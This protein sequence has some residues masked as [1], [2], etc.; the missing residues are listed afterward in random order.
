MSP[1]RRR[2]SLPALPSHPHRQVVDRALDGAYR[3]IRFTTSEIHLTLA[4]FF[5]E[6][7][8]LLHS[9]VDLLLGEQH[10][11]KICPHT[12]TLMLHKVGNNVVEET[13]HL[14]I[15]A[16]RLTLDFVEEMMGQM[17]VRLETFLQRGSGYQLKNVE[18]LEWE[19]VQFEL[20]PFLT[21]H[22]KCPKLPAR[23]ASKKAVVNVDNGGGNDCF[24]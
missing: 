15:K 16:S 1:L 20:I 6:L 21:G 2:F 22:G 23:L 17:E 14:P 8:P 9:T 3:R 18:A 7:L 24:R 10:A 13:I 5:H 4:P 12:I 11:V 19:V